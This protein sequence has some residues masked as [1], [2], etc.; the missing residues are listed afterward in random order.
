MVEWTAV[1]LNEKFHSGS[2]VHLLQGNELLFIE[3][4]NPEDLSIYR[5]GFWKHDNVF[6]PILI[7]YQQSEFLSATNVK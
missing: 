5:E 4:S 2:A 1:L 3:C 6:G 7:M